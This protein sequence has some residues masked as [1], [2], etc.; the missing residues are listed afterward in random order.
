MRL[1]G[2]HFLVARPPPRFEGPGFYLV[3][4]RLR[5][6]GRRHLTSSRHPRPEVLHPLGPVAQLLRLD[7]P[8]LRRKR[9]QLDRVDGALVA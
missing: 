8:L 2:P 9:R 1:E 6:D 7:R 5:L 4:S 3:R